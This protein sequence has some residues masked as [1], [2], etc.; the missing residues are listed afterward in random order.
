MKHCILVAM[1]ARAMTLLVI[2]SAN[3]ISAEEEMVKVTEDVSPY[4]QDMQLPWLVSV[5]YS[6]NVTSMNTSPES[7]VHLSVSKKMTFV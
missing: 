4:F 6:L 7:L 3:A 2:T 1:V 5:L